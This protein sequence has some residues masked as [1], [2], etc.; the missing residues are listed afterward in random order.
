M[1]VDVAAAVISAGF[2]GLESVED[3]GR[4]DEI[5][6]ERAE[7]T[8]LV[9]VAS[10]EVVEYAEGSQSSV[11]WTLEVEPILEAETAELGVGVD[12]ARASALQLLQDSSSSSRA[13]EL[14]L[15][16][17]LVRAQKPLHVVEQLLLQA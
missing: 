9:A 17:A 10:D 14:E 13:L 6:V 8:S 11:G 15:E 2:L 16:Q 4:N 1:V 5:Q 12:S 7:E 3:V